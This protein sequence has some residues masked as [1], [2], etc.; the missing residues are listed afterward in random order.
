[1]REIPVSKFKATCLAV[2]DEVAKTQEPFRITR[3]GK[4]IAE[5]GPPSRSSKI[6]DSFGAMVGTSEILG[7]IVSPITPLEDWESL[8]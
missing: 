6:A 2:L 5:I 1:M 7:D 4:T 8:K 3:R